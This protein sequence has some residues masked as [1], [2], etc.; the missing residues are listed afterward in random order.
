MSFDFLPVY[1]LMPAT[2]IL[3]EPKR[4][5]PQKRRS[6]F[7]NLINKIAHLLTN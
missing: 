4:I 3:K 1:V 2:K 5:T 6:K 7:Q